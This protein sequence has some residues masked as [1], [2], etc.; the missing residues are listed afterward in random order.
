MVSEVRMQLSLYGKIVA[1]T[2]PEKQAKELAELVSKLGGTPYLVPTIEIKPHRDERLVSR[3]LNRIL[4][5]QIDYLIFMSVNSVTF[6]IEYL[7]KSGLKDEFLKKIEESRVI[8]IGPRTQREPK[9][10]GIRVDAVPST[11]T[12]EGIVESLKKMD[13]REKTTVILC[14]NRSRR[15]LSHGLRK[16][17]ARIIEVPIYECVPPADC[18]RI[19]E[20]IN[21]LQRGEIDIVTFTSSSTAINLFEIASQHIPVDDLIKNLERAV[22]AAIGPVTRRTLENLGVKVDVMPKEYTIEAMVDSL[23]S[24][25]SQIKNMRD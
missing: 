4:R 23:L 12:S 13:L 8:A 22:I 3:F 6:L 14:S 5:E 9:K 7:E 21:A 1:I 18:S 19:L 17:G 24:H 2:R 10:Y 15:F 25:V 16:L 20:F 11:Y